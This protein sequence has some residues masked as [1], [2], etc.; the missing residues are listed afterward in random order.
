LPASGVGGLGVGG[1]GLGGLGAWPPVV[2]GLPTTRIQIIHYPQ[3][4]ARWNKTL[5]E[6]FTPQE[7][8]L[9]EQCC[10]IPPFHVWAH[11]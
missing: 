3:T 10:P 11:E 1:A 5:K 7:L 9:L 4:T 6:H 8:E 2:G